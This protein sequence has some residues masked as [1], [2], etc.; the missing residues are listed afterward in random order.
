VTNRARV[1]AGGAGGASAWRGRHFAEDL[2]WQLGRID[3]VT[4]HVY[5]PYPPLQRKLLAREGVSFDDNG[6]I[7][8]KDSGWLPR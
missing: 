7:V 1:R 6:Y 8:L 4:A 5:R 2:L 3:G